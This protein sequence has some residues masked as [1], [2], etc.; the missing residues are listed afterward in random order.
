MKRIAAILVACVICSCG[1]THKIR[2]SEA[3]TETADSSRVVSTSEKET[4]QEVVSRSDVRID[5]VIS[6]SQDAV[7]D[8]EITIYDNSRIDSSGKAPVSAVVK[9]T[10]KAVERERTV[11]RFQT[12]ALVDSVFISKETDSLSSAQTTY[13]RK[14][15]KTNMETERK[16]PGSFTKWAWLVSFAAIAIGLFIFII[17]KKFLK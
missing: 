17:K 9:G 15:Q 8:F 3:L 6:S 13:E 11:K 4:V 16:M 14:E 7:I 10:K 2:T 1:T 12:S 5:S